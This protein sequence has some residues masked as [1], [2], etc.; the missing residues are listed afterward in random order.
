MIGTVL[1]TKFMK[2]EAAPLLHLPRQRVRVR[3]VAIDAP[4]D[5]VPALAR[6]APP[7][8]P[9]ALPLPARFP[10]RGALAR[11]GLRRCGCGCGRARGAR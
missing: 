3:I 8:A 10:A 6:V 1:V 2:E 5:E 7:G 11:V 4:R 9:A